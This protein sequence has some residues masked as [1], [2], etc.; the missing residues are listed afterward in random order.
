M[1]TQSTCCSI[2]PLTLPSL[3]MWRLVSMH[4]RTTQ[5]QHR[6]NTIQT[7]HVHNTHNTD[8]TQYRHN[9]YTTHTTQMQHRYNTDT[10]QT[11]HRHST[12]TTQTQ[13]RHNTDTTYTQHRHNTFTTQIQYR[14]ISHANTQHNCT[15]TRCKVRT[16]RQG[17]RC[18]SISLFRQH[19]RC[20]MGGI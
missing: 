1:C 16:Y 4:T 15:Q 13:H 19:F 20:C 9:T 6:H 5:T 14:H 2:S 8:T 10:T 17:L 12:Y 7:Q 11:Q 18:P 3:F